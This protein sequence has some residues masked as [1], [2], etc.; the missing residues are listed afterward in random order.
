MQEPLRSA[1][2]PELERMAELLWT[3]AQVPVSEAAK[4]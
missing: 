3:A 4:E 1:R 2:A